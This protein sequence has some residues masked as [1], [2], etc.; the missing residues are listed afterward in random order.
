MKFF[1]Q[2]NKYEELNLYC[3][4][5]YNIQILIMYQLLKCALRYSRPL[6]N[7]IL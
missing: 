4:C 6:K 7:V 1:S 2:F 5:T 3:T